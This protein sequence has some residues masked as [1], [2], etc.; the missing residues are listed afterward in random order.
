MKRRLA[1]VT[2]ILIL[3]CSSPVYGQDYAYMEV[4]RETLN[5]GDEHIVGNIA[6][7][8]HH[9]YLLEWT[10]GMYY[11]RKMDKEGKDQERWNLWEILKN[12]GDVRPISL[13]NVGEQ[14]YMAAP[15]NLYRVTGDGPVPVEAVGKYLKDRGQ[16]L[17]AMSDNGNH[18]V[19]RLTASTKENDLIGQ[20]EI[21]FYKTHEFIVVNPETWKIRPLLIEEEFEGSMPSFRIMPQI[22]E[23][24]T[25]VSGIIVTGSRP[26]TVLAEA[27]LDSNLKAGK[28]RTIHYYSSH[29]PLTGTRYI[30]NH[31]ISHAD[32]GLVRFDGQD[33]PVVILGNVDWNK[34]HLMVDMGTFPFQTGSGDRV[35]LHMRGKLQDWTVDTDGTLYAIFTHRFRNWDGL[36]RITLPQVMDKAKVEEEKIPWLAPW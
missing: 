36:A 31:L 16:H 30:K 11:L 12:F 14:V 28:F 34:H 33:K 21:L 1:A 17:G 5:E 29:V 3:L 15:N 4:L 22:S 10:K 20:S 6:V 19:L 24:M 7:A 32:H 26:N 8:R 18:L 2:L 13:A 27:D 25:K 35:G 9:I 23:D